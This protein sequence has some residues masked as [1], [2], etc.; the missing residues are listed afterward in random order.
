MEPEVGKA[1]PLMDGLT[2]TA[3][4][5]VAA[6]VSVT[7]CPA[8]TVVELAENVT[9]GVAGGL[10]VEAEAF[11][12]HATKVARHETSPRKTKRRK[13]DF[14]VTPQPPRLA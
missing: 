13:I 11:P 14:T 4:A 7:C 10:L 9:L 8:V 3:V 1:E 6:H 12:P 2:V 5:L